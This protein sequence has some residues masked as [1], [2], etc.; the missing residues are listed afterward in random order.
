MRI[1][2]GHETS[3]EGDFIKQKC[4]QIGYL[5][6]SGLRTN[7]TLVLTYVMHACPDLIQLAKE[8]EASTARLAEAKSDVIALAEDHVEILE[9]YQK[10][11]AYALEGRAREILSGLGINE[12]LLQK[13]LSELSGGLSMR[14][15]LA[16]LLL[17]KPQLLLLDE[18][19]NHLDMASLNWLENFLVDYS[20]AWLVVS[21]DRY[22]LNRMVTSIAELNENGI[23]SFTGNYD[24]YLDARD[25]LANR[26]ATEQASMAKRMG[27]LQTFIDRFGAKATKA[28]QAQSRA[29]QA[30]KLAQSMAASKQSM[31]NVQKSKRSMNMALPQPPRSGETVVWL[32]KDFYATLP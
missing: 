24:D 7:D 21:H 1:I 15:E 4:L 31:P 2:I 5:P 3:D 14:V 28:R 17:A 32:K 20:G 10:N 18:P 29:K 8:L 22:F 9:N 16:R 12:N 19:T 6:Q 13:P 26:L 23:L 25:A 11:E 27:Q 30:A